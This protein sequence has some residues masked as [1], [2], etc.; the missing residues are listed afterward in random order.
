MR[1]WR[2]ASPMLA[3]RH[4]QNPRGIPARRVHDRYL[5]KPGVPIWILS[6]KDPDGRIGGELA[7]AHADQDIL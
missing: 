2:G 4:R 1:H 6:G 5:L 7:L 3:L